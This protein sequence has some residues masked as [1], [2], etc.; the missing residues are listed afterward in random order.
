VAHAVK[1]SDRLVNK[2]TIRA[3]AMSRSTA[4][5]IEYWANIGQIAEDNPDLPFNFIQDILISIEEAKANKLEEYK[6]GEGDLG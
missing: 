2:A 6:F 5:Q 1:I 4:G 3:K